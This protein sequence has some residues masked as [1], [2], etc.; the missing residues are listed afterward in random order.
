M[1]KRSPNAAAPLAPLVHS[2]L[3]TPRAAA[4][5]GIV[6]SV[7]FISSLS[8]LW[9]S[10]PVDPR[11]TGLWLKEGSRNVSLAL[12]LLPFAGIAFFWFLGVLR[13]RL[14][15]KEDKFFA[16]VFFGS[17]L[18]FLGMMFVAASAMG[19]LVQAEVSS[20]DALPGSAT[21]A[22]VRAFTY[23][24]M[25]IY[26]LK[27]AAVFMITTSTLAISTELTARWIAFLGYACAVFLLVGNAYL[28]WVFFIFPSWVLLISV[29]ILR[30][31]LRGSAAHG[32]DP[33]E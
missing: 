26:V 31:N 8:M 6:F 24:L 25:H 28:D 33:P 23:D 12:S 13:D 29:F 20:P 27:M 32:S 10:L 1:F 17:G 5:A 7:L 3:R 9:R 2:G 18:L 16:T 19:A 14:G 4:I 30:D 21:F 11:D 15:E 22:V